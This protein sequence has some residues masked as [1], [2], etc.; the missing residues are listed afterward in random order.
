MACDTTYM[1][2]HGVYGVGVRE[3]ERKSC[4]REIRGSEHF[5][6]HAPRERKAR[7]RGERET[8]GYEPFA[9]HLDILG[10]WPPPS[11]RPPR[12]PLPRLSPLSALPRLSP[13]HVRLPQA[14]TSCSPALRI[15]CTGFRV[16]GSGFP[17]S[18]LLLASRPCVLVHRQPA[19]V[20]HL[21][22]AFEFIP[23]RCQVGFRAQPEILKQASKQVSN[24]VF[25]HMVI[26]I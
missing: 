9:I 6:L 17:I 21:P 24:Q 22:Q 20:A 4:E 26:R 8:R 16:S 10:G 5:A 11:P 1:G 13:L 14:G 15:Q 12:T 18:P 3:R 7:K 23:C 25:A 2:G 19:Q